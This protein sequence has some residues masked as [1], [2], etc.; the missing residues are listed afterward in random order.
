[1][2]ASVH[3][4]ASILSTD[5]VVVRK[6]SLMNNSKPR[7]PVLSIA[8]ADGLGTSTGHGSR[9]SVVRWSSIDPDSV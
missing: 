5:A 2:E 4:M 1:M 9:H 8:S 3:K 6:Q 7:H